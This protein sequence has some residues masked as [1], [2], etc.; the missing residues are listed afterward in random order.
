MAA[1]TEEAK[2]DAPAEQPKKKLPIKAI[3]VVAVL[4]SGR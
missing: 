2:A 4:M 1:K 3:G